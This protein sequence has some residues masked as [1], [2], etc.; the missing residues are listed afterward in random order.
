MSAE[1]KSENKPV[2]SGKSPVSIHTNH[3]QR[4][5]KKVEEF[6]LDSLE[7][8]EQLEW[9]LFAVIPRGDT[10]ATAHRLLKRFVT[11]AGVLSADPAELQEI[12][13]VGSVAARFLS[14][15]PAL[16]GIVERSM[17]DKPPSFKNYEDAE[18]YIQSFFYGRLTESAYIFCLNSSYRLLSV[19]RLN[20]G[21]TGEIAI[22]PSRVARIA[23]RE[24]A[25]AVVIAHNHPCGRVNPSI[26]DIRMTRTLNEVFEVLGIELFDSVIV[27]NDSICSLK[28]NGYMEKERGH[29]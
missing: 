6:G 21:G 10:N 8:H 24:N 26:N 11:I 7:E 17:K 12:E 1:D 18:K 20:D 14:Q 19:K 28:R 23:L 2:E 25:S 9:L 16:L 4:L 5:N 22:I 13:G 15:L 29:R 3:R 27:S